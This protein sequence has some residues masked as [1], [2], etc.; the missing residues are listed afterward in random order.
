MFVLFISYTRQVSLMTG[1]FINVMTFSI[2]CEIYC[3]SNAHFLPY[4]IS[5]PRIL[6]HWVLTVH[7]ATTRLCPTFRFLPIQVPT[8]QIQ[9]SKSLCCQVPT[10]AGLNY[11]SSPSLGWLCSQGYSSL[12]RLVSWHKVINH[13]YIFM[14]LYIVELQTVF[15]CNKPFSL[16]LS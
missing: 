12:P 10:L 2:T 8:F 3:N 4:D 16:S 7:I 9:P 1:A 15:M 6:P 5:L 14:V 11:S 13:I